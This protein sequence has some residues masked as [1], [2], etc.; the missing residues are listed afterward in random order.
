MNSY[1]SNHDLADR[2]KPAVTTLRIVVAALASGVLAYAGAAVYVRSLGAIDPA[3]DVASLLTMLAIAAAPLALVAS[4]VLPAV[5][6]K[7]ARR[8]IAEGKFDLPQSPSTGPADAG[9]S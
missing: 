3:A 1:A 9:L 7:G 4:R 5:V 8:R 6:A 2:L